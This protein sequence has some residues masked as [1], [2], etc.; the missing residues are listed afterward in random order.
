MGKNHAIHFQFLENI[1]EDRD[2]KCSSEFHPFD[3]I[4]DDLLFNTIEKKS[5]QISSSNKSII[6][7]DPSQSKNAQI[8]KVIEPDTHNLLKDSD[9]VTSRL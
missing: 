9:D 5:G 4:E 2:E 3:P 1:P 7:F 6:S 8:T